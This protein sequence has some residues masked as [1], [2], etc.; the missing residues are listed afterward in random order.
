MNLQKEETP[1]YK[2]FFQAF[3]KLC[4]SCKHN[5]LGLQTIV[6]VL[7]KVKFIRFNMC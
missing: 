5:N 1:Q 6:L 7:L 3:S 4:K 2:A